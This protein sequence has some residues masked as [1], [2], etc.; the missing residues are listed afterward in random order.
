M[1]TAILQRAKTT[2]YVIYLSLNTLLCAL[3]FFPWAQPRETISGITGRWLTD[4]KKWQIACAS[5]FVKPIDWAH[6]TGHCVDTY[7]REQAMRAALYSKS[8]PWA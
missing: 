4:G 7:L 5:F 6:E 2:I 8:A 1:L 3:M